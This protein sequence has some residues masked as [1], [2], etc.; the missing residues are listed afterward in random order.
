MVVAFTLFSTACTYPSLKPSG[1]IIYFIMTP[2]IE[3]FLSSGACS[4]APH[5]ILQESGLPF[6]TTVISLRN[7]FPKDKLHLNPKGLVPILFL[8]DENITEVPAILTAISQLVPSKQL[9]GRTNLEVVRTYEWLNWLSGK[10]HGQAFGGLFRPERFIESVDA[11]TDIKKK[12]RV[13]TREC[14]VVID[15]KLSGKKWAVGEEFTAVDAYLL[16]FYRWGVS[17]AKFDMEKDFPNY[18]R[19]MKEVAKRESVLKAADAEGI[20]PLAD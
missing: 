11:H 1:T 4:F 2:K 9:L 20:R 15:A 10:V 7:G 16:V 12:A 18:A 13:T 14:F 6:T 19:L 17:V 5:I 8:D 3:L